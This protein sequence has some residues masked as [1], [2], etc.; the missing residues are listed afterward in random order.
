MSTLFDPN[1]LDAQAQLAE[2][3][4]RISEVADMLH[5]SE[6]MRAIEE[7]RSATDTLMRAYRDPLL[8]V[9]HHLDALRPPA[10]LTECL[11][12]MEAYDTRFLL[13][14]QSQIDELTK[15]VARVPSAE[16]LGL[17]QSR[18][19]EINSAISRL[20]QPWLDTENRLASITAVSELHTVAAGLL[21]RPPFSE[22][23][24][25]VL[26]QDLGDWRPVVELPGPLFTDPVAR[27]D[28]YRDLGFN[29]TLTDFP[30]RVFDEILNSSG[31]RGS[32]LPEPVEAYR[33]GLDPEPDEESEDDVPALNLEAYGLIFRV[34]THL[35]RF[36]DEKMTAQ[37]GSSW[38]K[39]RTPDGMYPEWRR[40]RQDDIDAGQSPQPLIAYADFTDYTRIICRN[41][42]WTQVFAP[43]FG[44]KTDIEESLVRLRPVRVCTMHV[45]IIMPDDHLLMLAEATRIFRAIGVPM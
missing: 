19:G 31:L 7:T 40:K 2:Q 24:T 45:R 26:R 27:F 29:D 12:Q 10:A 38:V 6:L 8:G 14:V 25:A 28:F 15:A 20:R 9:Q 16:M 30:Q 41:D 44:R 21:E 18:I 23:L 42:N 4:S 1:F 37:F 5:N 17:A 34:E 3:V 36:I 35:R 32:V 13:P 33:H 39:Q 11:R 43:F 22:A